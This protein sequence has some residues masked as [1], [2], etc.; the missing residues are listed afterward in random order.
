M[1]TK[2]SA[3]AKRDPRRRFVELANKR[4][5]N[6]IKGIRLVGNLSN[7]RA[8]QYTEA[9]GKKIIKALQD[10]VDALRTRFRG[11]GSSDSTIFTL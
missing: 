3:V 9:E 5:T 7:K 6:A 2:N 4:V 1:R 11:D 8:Y 10:E